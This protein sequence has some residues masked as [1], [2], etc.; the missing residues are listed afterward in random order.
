[1]D[2]RTSLQTPREY[3]GQINAN[4]F[5]NLDNM[6]RFLK[7]CKLSKEIEKEIKNLSDSISIKETEFSTKKTLTKK[8]LGLNGITN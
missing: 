4:K 1:M 2:F 8:N 6:E 7:I 3:Y 5:N